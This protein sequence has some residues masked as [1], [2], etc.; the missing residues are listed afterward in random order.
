MTYG[1]TSSQDST[2]SASRKDLKQPVV[3]GAWEEWG[4]GHQLSLWPLGNVL[5]LQEEC[6]R[7]AGDLGSSLPSLGLSFPS[8][9]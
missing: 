4:G 8:I 1:A 2:G 3:D 9:K 6:G 7:E 5:L